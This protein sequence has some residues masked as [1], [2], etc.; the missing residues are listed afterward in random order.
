MKILR[1]KQGF[2]MIE[3]MIVAIIVAILAVVLIP[4]MS[5]NRNR[6]YATEA[7]ATLGTIRTAMRVASASNNSA[8]PIYGTLLAPIPV[9]ECI[10][11]ANV[12]AAGVDG[13]A[14]STADL[15]GTYFSADNFMIGSDANKYEITCNWTPT[16]G[17]NNAPQ[18]TKVTNAAM[19]NYKTVLYGGTGGTQ[20]DG[21]II[22]T[23]Y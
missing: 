4:L 15:M 18:N 5:A 2:T 11:P 7:E 22:R 13:I 10:L 21:T 19:V 8:F 9:D 3:L 16:Q 6:A 12:Q 20:L 14:F 17:A 23:G 1:N